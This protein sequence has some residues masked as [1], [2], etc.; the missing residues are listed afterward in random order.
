MPDALYCSEWVV[1]GLGR[2]QVLEERRD[3]SICRSHTRPMRPSS[4]AAI[5]KRWE[6]VSMLTARTRRGHITLVRGARL[7]M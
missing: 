4:R 7:A 6:E 5:A 1:A 2:L 3:W